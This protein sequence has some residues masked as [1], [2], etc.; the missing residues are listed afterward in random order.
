MQLTQLS[1]TLPPD[2]IQRQISHIISEN[3]RLLARYHLILQQQKQKSTALQNDIS[4][5]ESALASVK[6]NLEA[7]NEQLRR[8]AQEL[9]QV[10]FERRCH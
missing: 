8:N 2:E 7:Y 6:A 4:E 3:N 5:K 9:L 1:S 10:A